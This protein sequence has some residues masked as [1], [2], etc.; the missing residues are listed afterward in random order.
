MKAQPDCHTLHKTKLAIN[1]WSKPY[2]PAAKQIS[3]EYKN[4]KKIANWSLQ[5]MVAPVLHWCRHCYWTL[6]KLFSPAWVSHFRLNVSSITNDPLYSSNILWTKFMSNSSI[7][8]CLPWLKAHFSDELHSNARTLNLNKFH[9]MSTF[10]LQN[11]SVFPEAFGR[12]WWFYSHRHIQKIENW[13]FQWGV[14]L[15]LIS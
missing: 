4:Y 5:L 15:Q 11:N 3:R 7:D 9:K 6:G 14:K 2:S 12:V 8:H 1:Q 13:G 10:P